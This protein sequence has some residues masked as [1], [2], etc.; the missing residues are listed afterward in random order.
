MREPEKK[1]RHA[2]DK[3][4]ENMMNKAEVLKNLKINYDDNHFGKHLQ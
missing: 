3:T 2:E 4:A 1:L